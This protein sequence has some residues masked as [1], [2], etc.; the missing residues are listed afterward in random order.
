MFRIC[1]ALVFGWDEKEDVPE[2]SK[3]NTPVTNL[4]ALRKLY[5]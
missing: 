1:V 4:T 5:V 2:L 3:K